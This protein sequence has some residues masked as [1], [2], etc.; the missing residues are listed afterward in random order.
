MGAENRSGP[1]GSVLEH[2]GVVMETG[3]AQRVCL[4]DAYQ[5]GGSKEVL[6]ALV[7]PAI[8]SQLPFCKV[9]RVL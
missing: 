3:L 4:W 8:G 9:N 5:E 1:E 6:M 2:V 7:L